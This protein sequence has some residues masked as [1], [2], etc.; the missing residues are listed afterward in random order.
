MAPAWTHRRLVLAKACIL[1]PAVAVMARDLSAPIQGNFYFRQAHVAANI[2]KYVAQGLSL[3]PATY[4]F[5]IPYSLFDFPAYELAVAGVC[6]LLGTDPLVT[7][8]LASIGLFVLS[9]LVVDRLLAGGSMGTVHTLLALLFFAWAPL[10]LFYFQTPLPDC[11]A[12]S[13]S[14]ISLY[15]FLRWDEAGDR[16]WWLLMTA[17][18]VLSTL[19]KDPVYLPV[20]LGIVACLLAR[21][22]LRSLARPEVLLY[23]ASIA[24]AVILFKLY[25]NSVNGTSGF[26]SDTEAREYLGPLVDRLDPGSWARI[27]KVP[28]LQILN[29][30]AVGLAVWGVVA[31]SRRSRSP[32]KPL[33]LGTLAGGVTTVLVFFNRYTWHNYYFMPLV[34]PMAFFAGAGAQSLCDLAA[35]LGDSHPVPARLLSHSPWLIVV[36]TLWRAA[37]TL[38]ALAWTPTDWI[39]ANGKW[40]QEHSG[41]RDFVVYLL[42]SEDG[43]DWN[44]V[45]LYFARRDG[46]NLTRPR[47][48]RKVLANVYARYASGYQRFLI[49]CPEPLV[50]LAPRLESFGARL[51]EAGPRGR[52]YQI[53]GPAGPGGGGTSRF[54]DEQRAGAIEYTAPAGRLAQR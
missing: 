43:R 49:F 10:N 18:G 13:A 36:F 46:Y 45:F 39:A 34:F 2:E 32:H 17:S 5:D 40:I 1:L 30:L 37:A 11:L 20:S 54:G 27:L 8:R 15:A 33:F 9:F 50:W 21:R 3:K 35:G 16:K 24:G 4:N 25:S 26:L 12:I 42:D 14:L 38:P 28:T 19:V 41:A 51:L 23:G 7:A 48:K 22:G 52:L 29:P 6:R 31:Y 53:E 44:A 47:V